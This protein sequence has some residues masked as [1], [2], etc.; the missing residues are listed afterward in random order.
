[1]NTTTGMRHV[2]KPIEMIDNDIDAMEI[3]VISDWWNNPQGISFA[4]LYNH[5]ETEILARY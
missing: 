3:C 1:M 4:S 2:V 5:I